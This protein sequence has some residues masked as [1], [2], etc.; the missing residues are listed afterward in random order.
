MA[1]NAW[2]VVDSFKWLLGDGPVDLTGDTFKC[3][4][5]TTEFSPSIGTSTLEKKADIT[6]GIVGDAD[7]GEQTLAS[8]TWLETNGT[9]TFDSDDI[10]FGTSVTLHILML[11]FVIVL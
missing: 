3:M 1:A 4:L 5:L 9:V 7:Y 10:S 6:S 11:W 2:Q 8:V